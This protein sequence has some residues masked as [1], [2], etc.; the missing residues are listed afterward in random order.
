M[1]N[2]GLTDFVLHSSA[3]LGT[4][5]AQLCLSGRMNEGQNWL[6]QNYAQ[7]IRLAV[8]TTFLI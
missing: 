4:I 2:F 8:N 6:I 3:H 1:R 5:H 7:I